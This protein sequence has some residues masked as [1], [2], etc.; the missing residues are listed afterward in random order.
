MIK[1]IKEPR[2][3]TKIPWGESRQVEYGIEVGV[4]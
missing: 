2:A 3:K 4:P 1:Q